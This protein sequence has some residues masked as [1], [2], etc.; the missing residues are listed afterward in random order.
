[1]AI[2][3]TEI[4]HVGKNLLKGSIPDQLKDCENLTEVDLS[5]N[6]FIGG[7]ST[8]FGELKHLKELRL[9]R[10]RLTG[11]IP[12]EIFNSIEIEIF[13]LQFNILTGTIP[14]EIQKLKNVKTVTLGHNLLKGAIPKEFG[15]MEELETLQLNNNR[16]TGEAPHIERLKN[17]QKEYP[18]S[19]ITD[20]GDPQFLVSEKLVC[21]SCTICCNSLGKCQ[22]QEFQTAPVFIWGYIVF[23]IVPP[24][25]LLSLYIIRTLIDRKKDRSARI[26]NSL[27]IHNENSV[28]CLIF[29]S[30]WLG[31]LVYFLMMIIQSLAFSIFLEKTAFAVEDTEWAFTMRCVG[32]DNLDCDNEKNVT[33]VG[34]FLFWV[35][36]FSFL[37]RD[38][39]DSL[40]QL[41]K[42]VHIRDRTF[43]LS[44][45]IHCYLT[46][47]AFYTSFRYNMAL[48]E[49]N[50]DLIVNAVILLFINE[51]DES[52]L[53][54]LDS[55]VPYWI[56]DRYEEIEENL[57]SKRGINEKDDQHLRRNV[58]N[59][60]I[61]P[62]IE[63]RMHELEESIDDDSIA[64]SDLASRD[65]RAKRFESGL[66]MLGLKRKSRRRLV[67]DASSRRM[68]LESKLSA[69]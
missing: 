50:T 37:G 6:T 48:A 40:L 49:S 65:S 15:L 4:I 55:A 8:I 18:A 24:A 14:S 69:K 11:S 2:F 22:K 39:V 42:A 19:Y 12:A 59:G 68:K 35:V 16:F 56:A 17:R 27:S 53:N 13:M 32:T 46:T 7:I 45:S 57:K 25:I 66:R 5:S 28:F 34:W 61:I 60:A 21:D 62:S 44:G 52:V 33:A 58:L 51:L 26:R 31:W 29:S 63:F 67:Q 54:I 47:L 36:T 1:M 30:N 3:H 38:L 20:C 10:N 23:G 41:Q 64:E 43:L 9:D